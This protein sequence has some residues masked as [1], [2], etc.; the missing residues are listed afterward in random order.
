MDIEIEYKCLRC[1]EEWNTY[2]SDSYDVDDEIP[3]I[4][5][6]CSMPIAQMIQDVWKEE[7]FRGIGFILKILIGKFKKCH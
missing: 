5:P 7:G 6:L 1:D 3:K 2:I 4:C